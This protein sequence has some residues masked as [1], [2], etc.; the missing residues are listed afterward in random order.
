MIPGSVHPLLMGGGHWESHYMIGHSLRFRGAQQLSKI[1]GAPTSQYVF[2]VSLRVKRAKNNARQVLFGLASSSTDATALYFGET[3]TVNGDSLCLIWNTNVNPVVV[4]A[5]KFRDPGSH[6]DILWSQNGTSATLSV[7]GSVVASGTV[8]GTPPINSSGVN[9][10]IGGNGIGWLDGNISDFRFI[11]GQALTPSSFGRICP[12][13]GHWEPIKYTGTY[14]NNGFY[15]PFSNG[16]SQATLGY[17][18]SDPARGGTP[19][20]WTL[21]WNAVDTASNGINY[22][23]LTDTPTN[24]HCTLNPIYPSAA[25]ISAGALRSGTTA[26][27]GT[28]DALSMNS[29]WEV[30]AGASNV[31]AGVISASGTTN[32]TTVTANKVFGF[33]LSIGGTLKYRNI[34]DA[35]AWTDITTG[36]TGQQFPYGITAAA[37]WN[38]GQRPFIGTPETGCYPPN[39]RNLPEPTV[40]P[41]DVFKAVTDSGANV[42]ATLATARAGWSDY[43]EIFKRR[44]TT[45]EG[46]RW[47]FSDDAANY[48]DSS[49]TAAKAAF[50][51]LTGNSYLGY[52]LHVGAAYGVATGRLSHVNGAADTVADGLAT[53]RKLVILKNEATG[54]WYTYHPDLTAGKLLYLE[55]LGAESADTTISGVNSS[56]FTV[57]AALATGTYRWIAVAEKYGAINLGSWVGNGSST[58]GVFGGMN[59]SPEMVV[60]KNTTSTGGFTTYDGVRSPTNPNTAGMQ[61]NQQ[62]I[63]AATWGAH[64]LVSN[65]IK[66]RGVANN[67]TNVSGHKYVYFAFGRLSLKYS[68]AR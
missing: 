54:I 21:S 37:D 52:A 68:N 53:T 50:P 7:N 30:T 1:F 17:D 20:D 62:Y 27:R 65:G 48:L 4:S 28:F 38:F 13:K 32:T 22:D 60:W 63:E 12:E 61:M 6:L 67:D 45:T 59:I 3:G 34:T 56:G 33:E 10:V 18:Y 5:A 46:W 25:N 2:T 14:G 29:Y 64:D 19:R 41:K 40:L 15:L 58:D 31:T 11:D 43:I 49:S 16:A 35:G 26:V 36:L 42:Q 23:W 44:D 57:A 47:R 9:H 66:A 8:A 55:S 24:N 39:A 51:A